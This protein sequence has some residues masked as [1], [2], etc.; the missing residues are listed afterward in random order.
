MVVHVVSCKEEFQQQ[1]VDLLWWKL[2]DRAPLRQV[3]LTGAPLTFT[4]PDGPA[5]SLGRK[6]TKNGQRDLLGS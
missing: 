6:G 4:A 1:K 3:E 2:D 5:Q